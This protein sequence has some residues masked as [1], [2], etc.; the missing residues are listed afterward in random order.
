MKKSIIKNCTLVRKH[1]DK[2]GF[3]FEFPNKPGPGACYVNLDGYLICPIEM[4]TPR[5][6]KAAMK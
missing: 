2:S 5:Q 1:D 6:I 3:N 4:F